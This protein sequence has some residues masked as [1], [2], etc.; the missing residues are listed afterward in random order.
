MHA[1]TY[2]L[3]PAHGHNGQSFRQWTGRPEFN[4]SSSHT[5]DSKNGA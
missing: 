4:P 3:I 5:T 1:C 2:V